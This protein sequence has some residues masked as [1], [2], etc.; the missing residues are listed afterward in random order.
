MT[1]KVL[2]KKSS[3]YFNIYDNMDLTDVLIASHNIIC[4]VADFTRCTH[5]DVLNTYCMSALSSVHI[6]HILETRARLGSHRVSCKN[7]FFYTTYCNIKTLCVSLLMLALN[8]LR[9]CL[10]DEE[11]Y[12]SDN[13]EPRYQKI[14]KQ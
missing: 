6:R 8:S 1:E 2:S 10:V 7:V 11:P 3:R 12:N 9:S 14:Y 13:E 4:L 5:T